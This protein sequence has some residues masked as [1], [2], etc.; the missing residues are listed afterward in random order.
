MSEFLFPSSFVVNAA[1]IYPGTHN[2]AKHVV[3][4]SDI[5]SAKFREEGDD[6]SAVIFWKK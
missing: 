4:A 3:L 6:A 5:P 2:I 1:T